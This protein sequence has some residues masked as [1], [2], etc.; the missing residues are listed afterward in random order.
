M[1]NDTPRAKP[2]IIPQGDALY[3]NVRRKN[4]GI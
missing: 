1:L 2:C 4:Y 3:Y